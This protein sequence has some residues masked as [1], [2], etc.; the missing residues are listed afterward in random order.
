MITKDHS[1]ATGR[2]CSLFQPQSAARPNVSPA[3]GWGAGV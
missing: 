2:L 1:D 3:L